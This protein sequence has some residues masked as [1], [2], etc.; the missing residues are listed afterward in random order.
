ME[1]NEKQVFFAS[2]AVIAETVNRKISLVLM[3]AYWEC[4]KDYSFTE[5][6]RALGEVLKNPD[7]KK[8]PYFPLPTDVVEIIEGDVQSKSLF[9]WTEVVKAIRRIGHYDSVIFSD[10]LIHAVICDMGGWIQLCQHT[11]KE[12][13]FIQRDFERRYQVYCRRQ[14][15]ILPNQLTGRLAHQNAVNGHEKHIPVAI[16]FSD[17]GKNKSLRNGDKK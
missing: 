12:L 1:T 15:K 14:P 5:V 2:L 17:N 7:I 8:H 9:A 3:K 13:P 4:L 11:E 16:E 6:Q 10:K